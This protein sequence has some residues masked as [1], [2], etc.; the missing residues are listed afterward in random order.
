MKAKKTTASQT[1]KAPVASV[2]PPSTPASPTK[3]PAASTFKDEEGRELTVLGSASTDTHPARA[4]AALGASFSAAVVVQT[5]S[6]AAFGQADFGDLARELSDSMGKVVA[7]DM[8]Q[9]EAMLLGQAKALQSMF[10]YFA[11][12]AIP[13][14]YLRHT[15]SYF[16]MAMKAQNQ[17]RM[18]LETLGELKNPRSPTFVRAAQANIAQQQQVN[19][20]TDASQASPDSR[21]RGK[22]NQPNKVLEANDGERMDIPATGSAG[23]GDPAM[24]TVGVLD[25]SQDARG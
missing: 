15:E 11:R 17:C 3:P 23:R 8:R 12:Q 10:T 5:Y 21:A 16:N 9:I 19:N 25:R 7:G 24:E 14:E 18:T 13:R 20:G 6:K 1:R 22:A 2:P 4:V